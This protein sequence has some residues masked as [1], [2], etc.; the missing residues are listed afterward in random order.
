MRS[1]N[2]YSAVVIRNDENMT[3]MNDKLQDEDSYKILQ[4]NKNE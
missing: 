3:Y 4:H 2:R 1:D